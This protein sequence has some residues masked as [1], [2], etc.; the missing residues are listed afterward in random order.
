MLRI[1]FTAYERSKVIDKINVARFARNNKM[2]HFWVQ[3]STL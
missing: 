2:R 1:D 3:F